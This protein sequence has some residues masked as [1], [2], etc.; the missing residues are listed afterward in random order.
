MT[1]CLDSSR[2][3]MDTLK[4]VREPLLIRLSSASHSSSGMVSQQTQA[5]KETHRN[6]STS[7][8]ISS[9]TY[10]RTQ[11]RSTFSPI[12]SKELSSRRKCVK[13]AIILLETLIHSTHR[14]CT[15]R[16]SSTFTRVSQSRSRVSSLTAGAVQNVTIRSTSANRRSWVS[17]QTC[18]SCTYRGSSLT[19]RHTKTRSWL[20]GSNTLGSW[21]WPNMELN[22]TLS[23]PRKKRLIRRIKR[24]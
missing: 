10:W 24:S 12:R 9:R 2:T 22:K 19:S 4:W 3:S 16:T 21:I 1:T 15:W 5:S 14:R 6:S 13:D 17:C 20:I 11:V 23:W 18:S 8:S 7:S